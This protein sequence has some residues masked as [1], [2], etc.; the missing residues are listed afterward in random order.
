MT[1]ESKRYQEF[2]VLYVD[3]EL[4]SLKYFPR[5]FPEFTVK[6]ASSVAEAFQVIEAVGERLALVITDQRMPG[7]QGT[8]LLAALHRRQP[9]VVRILTTSHSDLASA[10]A[11][12]N[13][14][15]VYRY[16]EKPWQVE[17]LRQTLRRGYELFQ[18]QRERNRLLRE[19]LSVLQR[20]FVMD[21]V[22]SYAVLAAGL[23]GRINH[24]LL[25]L[26]AFLDA[27]PIPKAEASTDQGQVSWDQLWELAR[28]ESQRTID[29]IQ[30]VAKR[31]IEPTYH[32]VPL[33]A[34]KVLRLGVEQASVEA[35]KHGVAVT[36]GAVGLD[37]P[38]L[39][40]DN[41]M[42]KRMAG[43]MVDRLRLVDPQA[44]HIHIGLALTEVWGVPGLRLSVTADQRDWSDLELHA[45]FAMLSGRVGGESD[46]HDGDLLVAYFIAYHHAGTFAVHRTSPHGPGFVAS[47]PLDP[48]HVAIPGV[49]ADWLERTFTWFE[50]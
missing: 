31:T 50:N 16:V 9:E 24:S 28:V 18:L 26:K 15:A 33:D 44:R 14:G 35:N 19:K 27:A 38:Q 32:F 43:I 39:T 22:R 17:D 10:I 8:E 46:N 37:L 12:V 7:A 21:R 20:M 25:A 42:L 49:D 40:A 3:D 41:D 1:E 34:E 36:W 48:E 2:V 5:T 30:G 4:Q 23:A 29:T 11:A 6:T 13:T 47:L 45:C